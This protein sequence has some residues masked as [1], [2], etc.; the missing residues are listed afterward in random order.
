MRTFTKGI[1]PT[2]FLFL[3]IYPQMI[4]GFPISSRVLMGAMGIF[5]VLNKFC[6]TIFSPFKGSIGIIFFS[7]VTG[8]YNGTYDFYFVGYVGSMLI[9]LF[10]SYLIITFFQIYKNTTV[11][12]DYLLKIFV[13]AVLLQ[14]IITV[15]MF[16]IPSLGEV[17]HDV[18]PIQ[19]RETTLEKSFGFRLLGLGTAFF[20]AGVVN[21]L[22]L[23]IIIYLYL[24]GCLKRTLIWITYYLF[25]FF[26]G[27]MMARTTIVGMISSLLFLATWKPLSLKINGKKFKWAIFLIL[28]SIITVIF[29]LANA[30]ENLLNFAFEFFYTYDKTGSFESAS[31]N[32]MMTMYRW[33]SK[34]GTWIFGDGIFNTPDGY[35]YMKTDI[36]FLRLIYYGGL[37]IMFAFFYFSWYIILQIKKLGIDKLFRYFLLICFAYQIVLNFK[38]LVDINFFFILIFICLFLNKIKRKTNRQSKYRGNNIEFSKSTYNYL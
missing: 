6:S 25:I 12:I 24:K 14:S 26:I 19:A 1:F 21:G 29:L 13:I 10:A 32:D 28:I 35:Y 16:L 34:I 17:L 23:I 27:L 9:I 8:I 38:G 5:L 7:V 22:A 11:S 30:N 33:P 31:T 37:P 36:G 20:G 3:F 2:I 18:F 4:L 15:I